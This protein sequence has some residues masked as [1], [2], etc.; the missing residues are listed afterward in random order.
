MPASI[1][2]HQLTKSYGGSRGIIEV[3][4][5]IQEGEV[6]GFLG[7]NGAGKTTT[8][9]TL[10]GLLR[11]NSGSATIGGLDCWTQS[12][13]VKQLVGYLPGEFTFDPGLRGAQ[14]IEYLGHLRGGVDQ[15]YVRS[16]VE[17]LGLDPS[18]RFRE[19]SH[20]N[21]QKL[22]LVQAFLH[23]PR[24]LILDEPTSGL[25]PLNQQEF[26]TMVAEIH[27][28]GRTVF[29]SSHILPEVEQTCDRVAIIREGRLVTIDHVSAL[30]A[31]R[32]RDVEIAFAAPASVE[33]FKQA[34]DVTNVAQGADERTLQLVVQGDLAEIIQIAGQHGA[35]NIATHEPSLEEAFLRFY[36]PQQES[37]A[38]A[39]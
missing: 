31:I 26:Y 2:T 22:G 3:T 37:S 25:D 30:K 9:R 32:Q 14:I 15:A 17:R 5:D 28:Q 36:E 27:A 7:P 21:K 8:M 18:K 13:E 33:W 20:G 34:A 4:F 39:G 24:L 1:Q 6:F 23:Q 19:Y 29:L 10:M 16:L 12:T 11:G 35:T 38:L